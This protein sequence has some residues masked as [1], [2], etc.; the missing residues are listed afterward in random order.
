MTRKPI[1]LK[2]GRSDTV[3]NPV[4]VAEILSTSNR[5]YDYG[6]TFATYRIIMVLS[7][8]VIGIQF[9][10]ADIYEAIECESLES[11]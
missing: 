1:E 2:P 9:K 5:N 11:V 6:E 10:I 8:D 3:M 7:L 4:L